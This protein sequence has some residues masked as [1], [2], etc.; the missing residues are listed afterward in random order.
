M[1]LIGLEDFYKTLDNLKENADKV[2]EQ[3]VL[4]GAEKIRAQA[5]LM[6]PIF[7]G[8]LRQSIKTKSEKTGK[9]VKGIVYTNKAYAAYVE[10]GTGPKGE[11]SDHSDVS[12]NIAVSYKQ[13]GWS[14]QDAEGNWH[15]TRG[16]PANP[17]MYP[18]ARDRQEVAMKAV[19]DTFA[20][21]IKKGLKDD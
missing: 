5:V 16:Q 20:K 18:A 17:F 21:A 12:P 14:Y 8:E 4:A 9:T 1:P 2:A 7:T 19:A 11:E 3:A 10:F 15:H 13:K 6:T